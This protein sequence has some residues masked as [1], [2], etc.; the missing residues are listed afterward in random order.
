MAR[1]EILEQAIS[2]LAALPGIGRRSASRIAMHLLKAEE[3]RA[4]ALLASIEELRSQIRFC[5]ICGGL[6]HESICHI[7][8]DASRSHEELC[9]V[10]EP[11]D[12]FAI[13][14]TGEFNGDYHVLMGALSPL[15]GIGPEELTIAALLKRVE[16]GNYAEI[17]IATNPTLEGDATAS[18]IGELL[19]GKKMLLTRLMH[20][21]PTGSA[22]EYADNSTLA[23]SIRSRQRLE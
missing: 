12:I 11:S 23:R 7:C 4:R 2:E 22:L 20:G 19:S 3:Y 1:F 10:E 17:F 13:E 14:N 21:I 15:D 18:Y 5:D 9:V 6:S 16:S 8:A